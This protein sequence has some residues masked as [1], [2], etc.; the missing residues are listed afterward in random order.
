[1]CFLSAYPYCAYW[2]PGSPVQLLL[3]QVCRAQ[4]LMEVSWAGER[5]VPRSML[6]NRG[7][8]K[9]G[10]RPTC[11]RLFPKRC[12]LLE[13]L[14]KEI[15]VP[16]FRPQL[17]SHSVQEARGQLYPRSHLGPNATHALHFISAS[18]LFPSKNFSHSWVFHLSSDGCVLKSVFPL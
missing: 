4:A 2:L 7:G 18:C 9:A 1:M 6:S 3:Y 5:R 16:C 13:L 17:N 11:S 12:F 10:S 14:C 15:P 8:K